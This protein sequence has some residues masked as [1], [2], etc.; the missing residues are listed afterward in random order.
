MNAKTPAV[1]AATA[2][3]D[4]TALLLDVLRNVNREVRCATVLDGRAAQAVA[5][6]RRI[7]TDLR[8]LADGPTS[9]FGTGQR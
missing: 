1:A 3:T 2:P 9:S 7:A 6:Y 8:T 4:V 5:D